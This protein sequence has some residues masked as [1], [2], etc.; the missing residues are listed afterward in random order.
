MSLHCAVPTLPD[1]Q[2]TSSVRGEYEYWHYLCDGVDDRGWG[3]GYR[4][5]QTIISWISRNKKGGSV[6][7]VP[8]I[9]EIQDTLVKMG[10][11]Q[12][13]FSG[14]KEWIGSVEV[15]LV[16]D[17]IC[18]VPGKIVHARSGQELE[19]VYDQLKLHFDTTGCPAM[20]GGDLDASSKGVFGTCLTSTGKYFLIID[21]HFVEPSKH[22]TSPAELVAQG[23][24]SWV[25]L[26]QFSSSSFYNICLPQIIM[27]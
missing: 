9:A 15:A 6:E 8:S 22:K 17:Q 24:A 10:D 5:L 25:N 13:T 23:W 2:E 18:D 7:S 3:C 19:Q 12:G 4:T 27:L 26:E 20:M 16:L 1:A 11:K 21:P 14:S